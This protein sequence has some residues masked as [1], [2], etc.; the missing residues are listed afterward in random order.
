METG[1]CINDT[2]KVIYKG[3]SWGNESDLELVDNCLDSASQFRFRDNGAMLNLKRQGCLNARY[4]YR[5]KKDFWHILS[6]C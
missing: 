4:K 5:E 2:A 1:K 6:L 3:S